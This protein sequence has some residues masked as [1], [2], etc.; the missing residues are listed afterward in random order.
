KA[1]LT[2]V[3]TYLLAFAR[4]VNA[5]WKAPDWAMLAGAV[6]SLLL[7]LHLISAEQ[8]SAVGGAL[9]SLIQSLAGIAAG[10]LLTVKVQR[11]LQR[12]ELAQWAAL[13]KRTSDRGEAIAASIGPFSWHTVEPPTVP[14]GGD[15]HTGDATP[16]A[17]KGA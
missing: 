17:P 9:A 4:T 2:A 1:T 3:T 8:A 10:A 11:H 6:V 15:P 16:D 7:S 12:R 13:R 14:S 5:G